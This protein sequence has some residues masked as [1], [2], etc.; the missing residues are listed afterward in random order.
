MDGGTGPSVCSVFS[1]F[2]FLSFI[3]SFSG[4]TGLVVDGV[5]WYG[6]SISIG[7]TAS[8]T[9]VSMVVV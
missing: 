7:A 2:P 8:S 1:V 4:C 5:R 6:L 9:R 3:F